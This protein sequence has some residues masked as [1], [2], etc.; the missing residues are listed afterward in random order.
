MMEG[1]GGRERGKGGAWA[2]IRQS[3]IIVSPDLRKKRKEGRGERVVKGE[4]NRKERGR[5]DVWWCP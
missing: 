2:Y 5:W 1:K 3:V 4:S